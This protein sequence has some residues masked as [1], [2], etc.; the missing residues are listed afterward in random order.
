M[1]SLAN[2]IAQLPTGRS[3]VDSKASAWASSRAERAEGRRYFIIVIKESSGNKTGEEIRPRV[4]FRALP[5]GP[6][7]VFTLAHAFRDSASRDCI[8]LRHCKI[9]TVCIYMSKIKYIRVYEGRTITNGM[10]NAAAFVS[11]IVCRRR[12][13]LNTS[14]KHGVCL[15]WM[16]RFV[17]KS[18]RD[19]G[20]ACI[21]VRGRCSFGKI[22]TKNFYCERANF[23]K[24]ASNK[25][26]IGENKVADF[27]RKFRY[28]H[29]I[30]AIRPTFVLHE[31]LH[32]R[33]SDR[34]LFAENF[35]TQT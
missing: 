2:V 8:F 34:W 3:F 29:F 10:R 13:Y 21:G 12:F 7:R 9:N 18:T 24:F 32:H 1:V 22:R 30:F 11:E 26:L 5:R 4:P 15:I 35:S 31:R 19:L 17:G 28:V 27:S 14:I 20:C 6:L 23:A 33:G 25:L 16:K